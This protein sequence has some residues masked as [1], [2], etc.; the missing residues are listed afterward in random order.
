MR[1]GASYSGANA[2]GALFALEGLK[3]PERSLWGDVT[4]G[5]MQLLEPLSTFGAFPSDTHTIVL[6][7]GML[8]YRSECKEHLF[9]Y[10]QAWQSTLSACSDMSY[11]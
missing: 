8:V 5:G 2:A 9:C 3:R 7:L 6:F 10:T 1:V 4:F 11:S